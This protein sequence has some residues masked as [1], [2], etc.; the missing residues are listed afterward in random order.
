MTLALSCIYYYFDDTNVL[1]QPTVHVG[2]THTSNKPDYVSTVALCQLKLQTGLP[3]SNFFLLISTPRQHTHIKHPSCVVS[4]EGYCAGLNEPKQGGSSASHETVT[5]DMQLITFFMDN[6]HF[7]LP[8]K[9]TTITKKGTFG[10]LWT[11]KSVKI[12]NCWITSDGLPLLIRHYRAF[13]LHQSSI[14]GKKEF[15]DKYIYPIQHNNIVVQGDLTL[16]DEHRNRNR[17]HWF[18][19][20][21][22]TLFF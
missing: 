20:F 16:K 10:L 11:I 1:Y 14:Y 3:G 7:V 19:T 15:Y 17:W 5:N 4:P 13:I 8:L 18:I 12:K 2:C 21:Y 6:N 22:L 9:T